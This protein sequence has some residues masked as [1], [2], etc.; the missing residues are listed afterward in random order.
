MEKPRVKAPF[1]GSAEVIV[2]FLDSG[3]ISLWMFRLSRNSKAFEFPITL[4]WAELGRMA[5]LIILPNK[6]SLELACV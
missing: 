3:N 4:H 2:C 1:L 6:E 5:E